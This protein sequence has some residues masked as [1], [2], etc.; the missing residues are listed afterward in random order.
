MTVPF[1]VNLTDK[2]AVVTGGGGVLGSYFAKALAECGAKVAIMDLNQEPADKVAAEINE[3]GGKAIGVAANVLDKE[4]IEK[5]REIIL[6]EFGTVDI[7]LNG[8]GR[9]QSKRINRKMNSMMEEAVK[10]NPRA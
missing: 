4:A 10:N 5:A 7:L 8:A 2:V 6:K 3:A 1:K 9:K